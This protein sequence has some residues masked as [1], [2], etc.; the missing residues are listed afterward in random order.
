MVKCGAKNEVQT[1]D[2]GVPG[3]KPEE[4]QLTNT[5]LLPQSSPKPEDNERSVYQ[6]GF[7]G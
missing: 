3:G 4:Q 7:Q 1:S 5:N 6:E 2:I